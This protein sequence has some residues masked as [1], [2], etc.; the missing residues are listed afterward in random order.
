MCV[1]F[2]VAALFERPSET[3]FGAAFYDV[4]GGYAVNYAVRRIVLPTA[5]FDMLVGGVVAESVIENAGDS[6]VFNAQIKIAA[7]D[8]GLY[9]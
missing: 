4:G 3:K 6:V 8:I 9:E 5:V 7:F 2:E 1:D